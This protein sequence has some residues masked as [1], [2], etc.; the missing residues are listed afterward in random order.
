M[1]AMHD[2]TTL[3]RLYDVDAVL[4][5]VG[6][7]WN[8]GQRF[9]LGHSLDK[10]WWADVAHT[11]LEHFPT[12]AAA[13]V[14]E[15]A[16]I[17]AERPLHNVVHNRTTPRAQALTG[18]K[19]A[20][21][22]PNGRW[23]FASRRN[24]DYVQRADLWL[25]PELDGSSCVDSCWSEDGEDQLVFYVEWLERNE[26]DW[27]ADDAVPIYWSVAPVHETAPFPHVWSRSG[28]Y[29]ENFLTF[30]DW[31]RDAETGEPLD[32]F[33]LPVRVDRFPEFGNALRWTPSPFQPT[34]PLKSILDS[35]RRWD[36]STRERP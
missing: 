27:L 14:A 16:A 26:P 1:G 33:T 11:T 10:P 32:W 4:L 24:P 15:R 13:L 29:D 6:I 8:P 31:P 2:H 5:Y 20:P 30:Y 36:P 35:R 17:V 34:A 12:R 9:T 18:R 21:T 23:K 28:L 3:Y 22:Q 19:A 7:S 25:Y